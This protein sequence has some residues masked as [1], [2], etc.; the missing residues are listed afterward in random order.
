M[1]DVEK[2]I[3][4]L[5]DKIKKLEEK[6]KNLIEHPRYVEEPIIGGAHLR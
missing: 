4:I 1:T 5:E 2:R 6:V 3:N